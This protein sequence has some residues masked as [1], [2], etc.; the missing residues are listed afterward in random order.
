MK[1]LVQVLNFHQLAKRQ[2]YRVQIPE[3]GL[4]NAVEDEKIALVLS[5]CELYLFALHFEDFEAKV[6]VPKIV[7]S[8]E[9]VTVGNISKI[10]KMVCLS[11]D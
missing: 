4:P 9:S 1:I 10:S 8:S 11:N 3:A 5:F 2:V 6:P 7:F